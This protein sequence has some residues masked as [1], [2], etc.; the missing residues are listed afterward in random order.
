MK[1]SQNVLE[2]SRRGGHRGGMATV[3]RLEHHQHEQEPP[4]RLGA[5][6]VMTAADVADFLHLPV[7]TVYELTR[8]GELPAKR[9]GRAWRFLRPRLE[10]YLW[11]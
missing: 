2:T 9:V 6:D 3:A 5:G 8:R 7:S 11:S 1:P 4:E 10:E